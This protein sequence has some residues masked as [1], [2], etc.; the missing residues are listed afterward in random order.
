[1][2]TKKSKRSSGKKPV[3]PDKTDA[4]EKVD[5]KA[6][7]VKAASV[8]R[9]ETEPIEEVV[10]VVEIEEP[11]KDE[12]KVGIADKLLAL[13]LS[14]II[15]EL[16]GTALFAA[17]FITLFSNTSYGALGIALITM[18]LTVMFAS[19]S[20]SHFNPAITVAQWITRKINGVKAIAYIVA[21]V[22]GVIIAFLIMSGLVTANYDYKTTVYN[23]VLQAGVTED[24]L[25]EAGG[26]D[27]WAENYGGVDS[28]ASQLGVTKTAPKL[29]QYNSLTEKKEWAA[30]LSEIVGS[31]ILG[32]GSAYAFKHMKRNKMAAGLAV[33]ISL[34]VGLM[35]AGTT[36]ILNPALSIVLG[37]YGDIKGAQ[38]VWTIG[39]YVLGPIIGATIGYLVYNLLAKNEPNSELAE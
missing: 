20:G 21:Q 10:E 26:F 4:R 8:K 9:E 18:A 39:V 13:S 11:T 28:I 1:M 6:E 14:E 19:I 38:I 27:K 31:F 5:S 25:K 33:G 30:L 22:L 2:A 15:G 12:V 17:G 29:S 36:G 7:E 34:I 23:R 3:K 24:Q 35:V 37:V 32:L 16:I